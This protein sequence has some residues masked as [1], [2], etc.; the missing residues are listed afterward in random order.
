MLGDDPSAMH[1]KYFHCSDVNRLG[2]DFL[3]KTEGKTPGMYLMCFTRMDGIYGRG[4]YQGF[5]RRLRKMY[6]NKL[7]NRRTLIIIPALDVDDYNVFKSF[8]ELLMEEVEISAVDNPLYSIME[9]SMCDE[10]LN[11][12]S[13]HNELLKHNK[14]AVFRVFRCTAST[15]DI[16]E[17]KKDGVVVYDESSTKKK[18]KR[19]EA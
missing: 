10:Y 2:R 8:R 13:I 12:I 3:L 1:E 14:R 11:A 7:I 6:E 19:G 17:N 5:G 9:S 4:V 15:I 18:R 16:I